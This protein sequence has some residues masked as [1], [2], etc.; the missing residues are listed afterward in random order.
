MTGAADAA[1][2]EARGKLQE[3]AAQT[4]GGKAEQYEVGGERVVHKGG[5]ASMTLAHAAQR[6][7][8]LGGVYDGHEPPKNVNKMT[9]ASV[10]A[11]AGEGAGGRARRRYTPG[12]NRPYYVVVIG[13]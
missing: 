1:A 5:G 4:L 12:G 8:E 13:V 6:A 11:L 10:A 3:I 9:Q 2:M 7:I